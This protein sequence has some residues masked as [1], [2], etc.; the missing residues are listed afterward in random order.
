MSHDVPWARL[1]PRVVWKDGESGA[2]CFSRH[3]APEIAAMVRV[4]AETAP[5]LRDNTLV[6]TE[7]WR[8]GHSQASLHPACKAIDIRAVD[9]ADR[10]GAI[11]GADEAEQTVAGDRW[12]ERMRQKLGDNYDVVFGDQKHINHIHV[13]RD[14]KRRPYR[15]V[16]EGE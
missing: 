9:G 7:A 12:A 5:T 10:P 3:Y 4:A 14:V 16:K 8:P 1:G 2:Y 15:P 6:L 11:V 13:E